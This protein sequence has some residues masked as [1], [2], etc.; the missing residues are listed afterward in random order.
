MLA[1]LSGDQSALGLGIQHSV[2][3][4]AAQ[5]NERNV[6]PGWTIKVTGRDD[7]ASP[8]TGRAEVTELIDDGSVVAVVGAL[9]T[10][11]SVAVLP[12]LA[13]AGI[14]LVSPGNTSP[15]LTRGDRP[16]QAPTRPFDNFF[17]TIATDDKQP[18][19]AARHL[20]SQLE[21]RTVA[22]VH[23]GTDSGQALAE[24]FTAQF[25]SRGGSVVA[26]G[27]ID[28][29]STDYSA[30]V[31]ALR[32]KGPEAV[33]FGGNPPQAG[34]LSEQVKAA[35]LQIPLMGTDAL[36]TPDYPGLAG[37]TAAGDLAT[38]VI[39]PT[40]QLP[41]GRRFLTDYQSAGF[42]QPA[43]VFGPYAYDAATAII[44][45][46]G[47]TLH[48]STDVVAA[49]AATAQA[50]G[51]VEFDGA[52]GPVSFDEFGDCRTQP[53]TVYQVSENNEWTAVSTVN[54]GTDQ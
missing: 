31:R 30:M 51:E 11:V 35:D 17:R 1:P 27:A 6:V 19:V 12:D 54:A 37:E 21:N 39:G 2:E 40:Q 36:Y 52:I 48:D 42:S 38:S 26:D 33:F 25:T 22:V 50:L 9:N 29:Q 34:P 10:Q 45:A 7:Q 14:A 16:V 32:D 44:Q 49:R 46:L 47:R 4:A 23:D 43:E 5:A 3:L 13:E 8:D 18:A 20:L 24:A 28:P 15:V 53:V 41:A